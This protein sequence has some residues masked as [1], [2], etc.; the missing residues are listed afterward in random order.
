[1]QKK[2]TLTLH[3]TPDRA[4]AIVG[5]LWA[6]GEMSTD[7]YHWHMERINA[8]AL[9]E[10]QRRNDALARLLDAVPRK[11]YKRRRGVE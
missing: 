6:C 1:M 10:Q 7:K 8:G 5:R 3:V 9:A 4:A 11:F 2:I